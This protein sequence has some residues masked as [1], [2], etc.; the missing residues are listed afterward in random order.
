[1][2]SSAGGECSGAPLGGGYLYCPLRSNGQ[3]DGRLRD[4]ELTCRLPLRLHGLTQGS[5]THEPG[6]LG[7][8]DLDLCIGKRQG[9]PDC[10]P[11]GWWC[12]RTDLSRKGRGGTAA[13]AIRPRAAGH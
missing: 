1:M 8:D 12:A 7:E 10:A 11:P 3:A 9:S 13:R 6:M 2:L 5:P 4:A